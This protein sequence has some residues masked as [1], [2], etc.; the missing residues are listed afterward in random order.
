[1]WV[2]SPFAVNFRRVTLAPAAFAELDDI[3]L[4]Q[5]A[6]ERDEFFQLHLRRRTACAVRLV[7]FAKPLGKL[8][9]AV[10]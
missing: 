10:A 3:T 5:K 8:E 2:F 1:M 7:G 9:G 4:C 6:P